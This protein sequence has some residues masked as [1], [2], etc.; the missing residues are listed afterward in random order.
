MAVASF[1]LVTFFWT[2]TIG[3]ITADGDRSF[4]AEQSDTYTQENC[5]DFVLL[6]VLPLLDTIRRTDPV[7]YK[8]IYIR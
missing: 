7:N 4:Y 6:E 3:L 1:T 2:S 8:Q 5:S